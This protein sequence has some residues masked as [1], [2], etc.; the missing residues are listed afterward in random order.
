MHHDKTHATRTTIV[1]LPL[2]LSRY[3]GATRCLSTA[4][5]ALS[6]RS[7]VTSVECARAARGRRRRTPPAAARPRGPRA[8]DTWATQIRKTNPGAAEQS[9]RRYQSSNFSARRRVHL[10]HLRSQGAAPTGTAGVA[11]SHSS[12]KGRWAARLP[13]CPASNSR[14]NWPRRCRSSSTM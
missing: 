11:C 9:P 4:L 3:H 7:Q 14:A 5:R 12:V 10:A 6:V 8:P 13:S 2:H 1:R